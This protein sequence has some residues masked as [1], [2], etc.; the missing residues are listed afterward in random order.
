MAV[1]QRTYQ[2]FQ[3]MSGFPRLL[4]LL[5]AMF[6]LLPSDPAFAIP[7]LRPDWADSASCVSI[8]ESFLSDTVAKDRSAE[9]LEKEIL[10]D[11][12]LVR[13]M[14]D[15]LDRTLREHDLRE[16]HGLTSLDEEKAHYD[17]LSVYSWNVFHELRRHHLRKN[18]R[19]LRRAAEANPLLVS[20]GRPVGVV[21]TAAAIYH[22]EPVKF[23]L[24]ETTQVEARTHVPT[25]KG[26]LEV[27]SPWLRA[28]VDFAGKALTQRDP[29]AP[30]PA[31]PLQRDERYRVSLARPL[32]LWELD[33][34]LSY[35]SSTR[36]FTA[37]LSKRLYPNLTC[38]VDASRT[39]VPPAPDSTVP[40]GEET[41][42]L[43]YGL[44]F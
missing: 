43:F 3:L 38:V 15:D 1:G 21:A 11:P 32:P 41:V 14:R 44:S 37:A 40:A 17:R 35:G 39:L 2:S 13:R 24:F 26:K 10:F 34:G 27:Q 12:G 18:T 8:N 22:G 25:Q 20:I 4:G 30:P 6:G 29:Y 16:H 5:G 31:D 19:R 7:S 36:S 28:G 42:K 23:S 9:E 33:S